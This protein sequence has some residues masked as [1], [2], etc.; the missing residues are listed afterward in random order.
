MLQNRQYQNVRF[1]NLF[2]GHFA[3]TAN[4]NEEGAVSRINKNNMEVWEYLYNSMTGR[5]TGIATHESEYGKSW[6]V[7]IQDGPE[8]YI[9]TLPYSSRYTKGFMYRIGNVDLAQDVELRIGKFPKDGKEIAF[10]TLFQ[11]GEKIQPMWTKDNPG[12]M[13]QMVRVKIRG[14]ETWDDSD[15]LAYL[16]T[17]VNTAIIPKLQSLNPTHD[18]VPETPQVT[19]EAPVDDL[20]F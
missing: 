19:E 15:Q 18:E 6:K 7:T 3:V 9:L 12:E 5:I 1:I 14:Q 20:P 16:E 13:P 10:L 4:P 11:G 8:K 17:F 2:D